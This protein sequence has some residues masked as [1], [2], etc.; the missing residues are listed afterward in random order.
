MLRIGEFSALTQVSIKTLRHYDEVGLL[1]PLYVDPHSGYRYYSASQMAQLNRILALRDLDLSL[2][3]IA[4]LLKEGVSADALRGMLTLRQIDLENRV[5]EE[6]ETLCR[7]KARLRLIELEGKAATEVVLREVPLQWIASLREPIPAYRQV[8]ALIGKAQSLLGPLNRHGPKVVLVHE[9]DFKDEDIDAEAGV[10]LPDSTSVPSPLRVYQ[11]QPALVA[12]AVHHGP[13]NR[14]AE[15]YES[16]LRW[17]DA[18]GYHKK[19]PTRE[20]FLHVAV[21]VTREDASNVTEIQVPVEK[22]VEQ[23]G[24]EVNV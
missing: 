11:L 17:I 1:K 24:R 15:A 18:N 8:G 9:E 2:E 20:L 13:F 21:P 14:I 23:I 16:L 3:Q 7:V 10:Y 5:R 22:A 4:S 12:T 6:T 19:G